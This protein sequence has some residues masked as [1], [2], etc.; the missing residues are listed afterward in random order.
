[1]AK[2]VSTIKVLEADAKHVSFAAELEDDEKELLVKANEQVSQL[3][4]VLEDQKEPA[5]GAELL[6][7][8]LILL[9]YCGEGQDA[10]AIESCLEAVSRMPFWPSKK[11]MK[12]RKEKKAKKGKEAAQEDAPVEEEHEP[13]DVLTDVII[14]FLEASTSYMRTIANVAFG[15]LSALVK[16]STVDLLVAVS[17]FILL[18]ICIQLLTMCSSLSNSNVGLPRN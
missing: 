6:V 2:V 16:E 13:I 9:Q 17:P 4:K 1:M 14:G 3:K 5:R 12:E 10:E 18:F 15:Y 11:S 8:S 7:L